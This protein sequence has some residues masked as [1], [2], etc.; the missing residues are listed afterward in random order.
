V[1]QTLGATLVSL[2]QEVKVGSREPSKLAE[3]A[4]GRG[5]GR[6]RGQFEEAAAHGEVVFL[7]T[8]WEGTRNALELCGPGNLA[9]KVR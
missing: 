7:T 9:G 4:G 6:L 5:R 3:W 2:G 8:L 1:A